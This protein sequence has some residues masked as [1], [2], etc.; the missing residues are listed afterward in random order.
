MPKWARKSQNAQI[1]LNLLLAVSLSIQVF[2]RVCLFMKKTICTSRRKRSQAK[3]ICKHELLNS[4]C[5]LLS[6]Q[7]SI[8]KVIALYLSDLSKKWSSYKLHLHSKTILKV[9]SMFWK[10]LGSFIKTWAVILEVH[11]VF[12]WK[13]NG[14]TELPYTNIPYACFVGASIKYIGHIIPYAC[15]VGA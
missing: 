9:R 14:S 15:F 11:Q 5:S 2:D 1:F 10:R 12:L 3:N 8:W 7:Q 6:Y 4:Q 13:I